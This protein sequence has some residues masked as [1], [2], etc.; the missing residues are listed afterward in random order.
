VSVFALFHF[1]PTLSLAQPF[2]VGSMFWLRQKR[3]SGSCSF[4][5]AI[6]RA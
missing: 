4:F 5:Q 6:R 3:F 2:A 1:S